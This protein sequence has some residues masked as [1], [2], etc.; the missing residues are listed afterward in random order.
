MKSFEY[1]D[2][3]EEDID[4][5]DENFC[6]ARAELQEQRRGSQRYK[7]RVK[8][9]RVQSQETYMREGNRNTCADAEDEDEFEIFDR[10]QGDTA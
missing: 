7:D 3:N 9:M 2:D 6:Q 8:N 5:A 10:A 4:V 1:E